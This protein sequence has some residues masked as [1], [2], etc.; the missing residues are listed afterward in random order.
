MY[1]CSQTMILMKG[2]GDSESSSPFFICFLLINTLCVLGAI[3]RSYY[4][5]CQIYEECDIK[6]K[7]DVFVLQ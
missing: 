3:I 4:I 1:D 5:V 2:G 7:V 6:R